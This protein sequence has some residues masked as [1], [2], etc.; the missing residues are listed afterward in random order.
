MKIKRTQK[1]ETEVELYITA[2]PEELAKVKEHVLKDFVGSVKVSGFRQGKVPLNIVE[3]NVDRDQLNREFL[4]HSINQLYY[5]ATQE[6]NI[7]PVG[8]PK[9]EVMKV[10]PFDVL[11]FK[12][13]QMV[14]SDVTIP[15]YRN[16]KISKPTVKPV[17]ADDITKV[18]SQL[19][20]SVADRSEVKRAAKVGDQVWF[21]FY[22][23]DKSGKPINGGSG[24]NYPLVLGSDNFIPGFETNLIGLKADEDKKFELKFPK[25]YR[26]AALASKQVTFSVHIIK[27][28][29]IAKVKLDPDFVA[30]VS[31]FKTVDELE[32]DIKARLTQENRDQSEMAYESEILKQITDKSKLS[33]PDILVDEEIER[34]F[35]DLK[36]NLLYRGQTIAEFLETEGK[37]EE[38]FRKSELKPQAEGQVKASIVLSE[39]SQREGITV[40][41]QEIDGRIDLMRK[42]YTD[43]KSQDE[44]SKD[45]TKR[46]VASRIMA[47]KTIRHIISLMSS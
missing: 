17:T 35:S 3:K 29:E 2:E 9:I 41:N 16:M 45:E 21:D 18:I 31:P 32:A 44:L 26:I 28:E 4:E 34:K 27:V 39:I 6:E 38:E 46:G 8:Q 23:T 19:Q 10:V 37:T 7:R 42:Q 33:I 43:E 24:K 25:D 20:T 11:E 30:K 22:G 40:L 5:N 14:I 12:V 13:N 1:S 47:E 36:Q 15:D